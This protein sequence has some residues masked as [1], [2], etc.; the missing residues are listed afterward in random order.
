MLRLTRNL[1]VHYIR[2]MSV[3]T[4]VKLKLLQKINIHKNRSI[5]HRSKQYNYHVMNHTF[6][7]VRYLAL[8]QLHSYYLH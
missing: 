7:S 8:P 1:N 3:L 2:K 6:N 5:V 4:L